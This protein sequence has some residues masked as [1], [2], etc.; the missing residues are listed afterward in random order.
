VPFW[1]FFPF[2]RW[3][4]AAEGTLAA[5]LAVGTMLLAAAPASDRRAAL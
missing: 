5:L 3:R 4:A 2:W 1:R